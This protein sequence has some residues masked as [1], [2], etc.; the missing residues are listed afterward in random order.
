L[1]TLE[2]SHLAPVPS[3]VFRR[4]LCRPKLS[5]LLQQ[6]ITQ[7]APGE[8]DSHWFTKREGA[9]PL[10]EPAGLLES[11]TITRLRNVSTTHQAGTGSTGNRRVQS[12]LKDGFQ[13]PTQ[14]P[15][16]TPSTFARSIL[17][18]PSSSSTTTDRPRGSIDCVREGSGSRG[19]RI[20]GGHGRCRGIATEGVEYAGSRTL[21]AI[22]REEAV[23]AYDDDPQPHPRSFGYTEHTW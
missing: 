16:P 20:R 8:F 15:T 6:R 21:S 23:T 10:C 12:H 17:S 9:L 11:R 3:R 22:P 19:G 4:F 13:R 2:P 18:A 7:V 14:L 1:L 5:E